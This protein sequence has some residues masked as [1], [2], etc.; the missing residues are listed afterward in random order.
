MNNARLGCISPVAILATVVTAVFIAASAFFTG[1]QLFTAGALNAQTG[2]LIN[3][4]GS[5]AQI[6]TDCAKCHPSPWDKDT[7]EDR[8]MSCHTDVSTQLADPTSI[9]GA[10]MNRNSLTCRACHL[11]HRGQSAS[12]TSLQVG[13]FPHDATGYSLN[14]HPQRSD[15]LAFTC[16]DCHGTDITRFEQAVC[17]SCHTK[18]DSAFVD[19]HTQAY[20]NE[21]RRCHDGLETL[22]KNFN[23]NLVAFKLE[24]KHQDLVCEKC[25]QNARMVADF[26]SAATDCATCHLKDDVHNGQ[27][28]QE[29]AACHTSQAWSPATFDHNLS[30]FKL[31]G[32]HAEV[33]CVDCHQNKIFKGTPTACFA[34]HEKDDTHAGSLGKDC[35]TCHSTKDWTGAAFDHSLSNFKLTGS[36]TS[37]LCEKCHINNVLKGTPSDCFACHQK[38]DAH[39]GSFGEKCDVCHATQAWKPADFDHSLAAFKLTGSHT[40]VLCETCHVNNVFKG[41]P[42]NCVACHQKDDTHKGSLGPDCVLCHSTRAWKPAFDHNLSTFKL[43]GEHINVLCETCHINN[44]FK[45]TPSNCFAC[46]QKDDQHNGSLGQD[47]AGCH[48]T[49]TWSGAS[50]DHNLAAFKLSGAHASVLCAKCHINKVFKGTPSNCFAFATTSSAL[51]C[52]MP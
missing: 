45:G 26:K 39:K 10:M 40:E 38:D 15:G 20:G 28:G 7:M 33:T 29:C 6:G 9:H 22:N 36:H 17:I 3:G 31:V 48:S 27:L 5:H 13:K 21:C 37:V 52:G 1:S 44:V 42:S 14:S 16:S 24:G 30:D 4:V 2:G 47:C 35:S 49:Q 41:T 50:F 32:K 51:S 43:T 23:H 18:I 12:L 8:C 25:H 19:L 46:H 11:E 34:C